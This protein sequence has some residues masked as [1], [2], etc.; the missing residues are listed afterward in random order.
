VRELAQAMGGDAR[1]R[2]SATGTAFTITLP[3]AD[4]LHALTQR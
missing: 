2:S 3:V 1:V 4:G